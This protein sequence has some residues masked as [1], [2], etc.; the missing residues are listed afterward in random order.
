MEQERTPFLRNSTDAVPVPIHK[1]RRAGLL[2]VM[3]AAWKKFK[4]IIIA[5]LEGYRY[6]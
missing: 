4:F 2:R 6:D 1:P 5:W 3:Q